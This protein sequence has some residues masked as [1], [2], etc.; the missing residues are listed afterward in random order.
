MNTL[1]KSAFAAVVLTG[2][3]AGAA[4]AAEDCCCK[5]EDGKMTCCDKK[6]DGAHNAPQP[7]QQPQHRH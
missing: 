7:Q 3:A 2:F 5:D 4:F 1:V 6:G